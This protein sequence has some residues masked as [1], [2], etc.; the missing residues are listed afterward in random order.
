MYRKLQMFADVQ[1]ATKMSVEMKF[2]ER[3]KQKRGVPVRRRCRS[4]VDAPGFSVF[5]LISSHPPSSAHSPSIV[6]DERFA[7]EWLSIR[8]IDWMDA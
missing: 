6:G 1:K 5:T 8:V 7:L 4:L 2:Q 3:A